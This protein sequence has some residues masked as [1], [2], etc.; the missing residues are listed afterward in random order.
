MEQ[1]NFHSQLKK[2]GREKK[3]DRA[4]YSLETINAAVDLVLNGSSVRGAAKLK[5][6]PHKTLGR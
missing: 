3:T 2:R 6:I 1:A 5:G 4:S